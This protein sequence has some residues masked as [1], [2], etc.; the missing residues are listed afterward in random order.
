MLQYV[1]LNAQFKMNS[2]S[3]ENVIPHD[4][5]PH[6]SAPP[7]SLSPQGGEG[8]RVRGGAAKTRSF[9][10]CEANKVHWLSLIRRALLLTLI[11]V[12]IANAPAA[13]LLRYT[14]DEAASGTADAVDSG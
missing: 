2:S 7:A 13:L 1:T 3:S 14:F 4:A 10:P 11:L 5:P 9:S 8:L 6:T 12:S